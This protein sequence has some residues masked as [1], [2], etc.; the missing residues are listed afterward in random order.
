MAATTKLMLLLLTITALSSLQ[1]LLVS[2]FEYE[3]GGPK[4][5]V[6]PP[7]NDT[8][9][10]NDWAS[11]NRFQ[12]SVMEVT[13]E[14]YKKCNSSHPSFFSNTGNTVYDLDQPGPFYFISGVSGHCEKGQR[15]I[16]KVM[17]S[18]DH[19]GSAALAQ[20]IQNVGIAEK[21]FIEEKETESTVE[22]DL[23]GGKHEYPV[24]L[25]AQDCTFYTKTGRCKFG[26]SC[27]FN[28]PLRECQGEAGNEKEIGNFGWNSKQIECKY[29]LTA[30]GCKYGN[31]CRYSH[32]KANSHFAAP[33]EDAKVEEQKKSEGLLGQTEHT[34]SEFRIKK[35]IECKY[36]LTSGG[37]KYGE[38][39][40]YAHI[41]EKTEI[42]PVELNFLGL[43]L[44]PQQKECP[45]YMRT[46]SCGY[47]SDC[48]FHHPNPTAS[49]EYGPF[50]STSAAS[51]TGDHTLGNQKREIDSSQS[52]DNIHGNTH[53][54]HAFG[55]PSFRE[56]IFP[57][58][59][60]ISYQV[61]AYPGDNTTYSFSSPLENNQRMT[62]D[63]T[64]NYQE[65]MQDE[66][67]PERPDQ[68]ECSYFMKT[69]K[70]KFGFA[71][72]YNHPKD[73]ASKLFLNSKGLPLRPDRNICWHYKQNGTCKYGGK[74]QFNHP[75]N[76]VG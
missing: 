37:C 25:Y 20:G 13:E 70:C 51:F 43:P 11:E 68:P 23:N 18:G 75:E 47:G 59:K 36:Y 2:S 66:D 24:R 67:F 69:G 60:R 57:T 32:S 34:E 52:Y 65:K 30:E 7:P 8:R 10:Y 1:F 28:H 19:G 15:M 40:N 73:P 29:Y 22:G 72:R 45:F 55:M 54:S 17:S 14:D 44:R 35:S 6:V 12:D 71:C 58:A 5:W 76:H 56:E 74:C 27:K 39:C 63:V 38:A 49:G 46:G 42:E 26:P 61:P 4:G 16:I 33:W 3:V 64:T 48:L 62:V 31:L 53:P 41:K 9:I 50:N 21:D